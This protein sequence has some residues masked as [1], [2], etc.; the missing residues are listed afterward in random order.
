MQV[1]DQPALK[2]RALLMSHNWLQLGVQ[3]AASSF[4][5]AIAKSPAPSLLL[6]GEEASL[7]LQQLIPEVERQIATEHSRYGC[8]RWLWYLRRIAWPADYGAWLRQLNQVQPH[9]WPLRPGGILRRINQYLLIDITCASNALI[10]GI[11]I[12]RSPGTGNVRAAAFEVQCQQVI[13]DS[14]WRPDRRLLEVRG[15]TLQHD[16]KN[17]TDIDALGTNGRT[18]LLVSCKSIIYDGAYDKGEY[19]VVRNVQATVDEAVQHW[20][21]FIDELRR[22]PSGDNFDFSAVEEIIGVVC[23]PFVAYTSHPVS[24]NFVAPNLRASVSSAELASWLSS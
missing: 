5:K 23:T 16:G 4:G 17:L 21:N 6:S 8:V 19:R 13:N 1:V 22:T 18:L 7:Y 10:S 11:E 9:T 3:A 24:L 14:R 2:L 12:G 20:S 15:R